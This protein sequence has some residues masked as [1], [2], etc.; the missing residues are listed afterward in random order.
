MG[1]QVNG[2]EIEKKNPEDFELPQREYFV[3]I[4]KYLNIDFCGKVKIERKLKRKF[5]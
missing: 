1:H 3:Y 2:L 5:E 4:I